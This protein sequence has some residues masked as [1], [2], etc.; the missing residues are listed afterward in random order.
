MRH[1]RVTVCTAL[2][3]TIRISEQFN[4]VVWDLIILSVSLDVPWTPARARTR[5]WITKYLCTE[6]QPLT[7][8]LTADVFVTIL[9]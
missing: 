6:Y 4:P 8:E 1:D 3:T 5:Y 2:H 9:F 7:F